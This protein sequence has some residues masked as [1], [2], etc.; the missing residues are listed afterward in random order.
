M[1]I[2]I[3]SRAA[4]LI[5]VI[6]FAYPP[7]RVRYVLRVSATHPG[8][9][10]DC[11]VCVWGGVL[12]MWLSQCNSRCMSLLFFVVCLQDIPW[13][14]WDVTHSCVSFEDMPPLYWGR[15]PLMCVV[16]EHASF[17][18]GTWPIH[19]GCLRQ[20]LPIH[21]GCLPRR[22]EER[23]KERRTHWQT[24]L[25]PCNPANS[26]CPPHCDFPKSSKLLRVYPLS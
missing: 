8:V 23:K 7:K 24:K 6:L 13:D 19:V 16:W 4:S 26:G 2:H 10:C 3:Y 25:H 20:T 5:G 22:K 12:H 15:D 17:I 9:L 1:Y 11:S 21:I 18:L 14:T